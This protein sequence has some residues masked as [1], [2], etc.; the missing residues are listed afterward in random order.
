MRALSIRSRLVLLFT[1]QIV[2]IMV[3]G[4]IYLDWR[5]RETLENELSEKLSG[6]ASAAALQIE[7]ELLSGLF[8]G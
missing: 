6:L 2:L 1:L 7:G 3:V 8:L 5:L 4:G